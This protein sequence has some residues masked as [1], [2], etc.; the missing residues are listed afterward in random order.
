MRSTR[1][2]AASSSSAAAA[3][4]G[5]P[6]M[7]TQSNCSVLS[8]VITGAHQPFDV[9]NRFRRACAQ[10]FAAPLGDQRVVL[11][12]YTDPGEMLRHTG[13]RAHI[14]AGLDREHHARLELAPLAVLLVLAHVVH[15]EAEP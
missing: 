13:S 10:D 8:L 11:D 15:I 5:P 12:A 9:R 2:P 6:P 1:K 3:P 7:T 4:T 14:T